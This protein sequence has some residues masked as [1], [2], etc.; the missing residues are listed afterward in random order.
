MSTLLGQGYTVG[1]LGCIWV[2]V[3]VRRL[4]YAL[5]V[6][7]GTTGFDKPEFNVREHGLMLVASG[8]PHDAD[9]TAKSIHTLQLVNDFSIPVKPMTE[10]FYSGTHFRT[11]EMESNPSFSANCNVLIALLNDPKAEEHIDKIVMAVETLSHLW[12][13]G[14]VKDKW[15]LS[16]SVAYAIT[17]SCRTT[18]FYTAPCC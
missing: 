2:E 6:G 5:E 12:S 13:R 9:D 3:L 4:K 8:V 17:D 14:Q 18:R 11:F 7:G 15:V 1:D 16:T 10:K